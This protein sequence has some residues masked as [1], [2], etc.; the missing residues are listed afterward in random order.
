MVTSHLT[1]EIL[2]YSVYFL[3]S[4]HTFI[5]SYRCSSVWPSCITVAKITNYAVN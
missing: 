2:M 4:E 1:Y 3:T 5:V